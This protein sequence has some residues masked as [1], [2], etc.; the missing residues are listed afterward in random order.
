MND[1]FF[2]LPEGKREQ[3]LNG[4]LHVF[5]KYDYKKASMEEIAAAAGFDST[6]RFSN[7]FLRQIGV[8]PQAYR[9]ILGER[10]MSGS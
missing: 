1:R 8:L 5:A 10:R 3:M 9:S 4:A 2:D 6:K 7:I